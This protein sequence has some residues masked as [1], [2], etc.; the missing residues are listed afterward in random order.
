MKVPNITATAMIPGLIWGCA[1]AGG[2]RHGVY[3]HNIGMPPPRSIRSPDMHS[4]VALMAGFGG[5][6]LLMAFAEIDGVGALRQI[7]NS[8][9]GIR[10]DFLLRTRLL[11]RIRG[12]VYVSGTY[13]RD[14]LLEPEAG[15]AEGHRYSLLETRH[16]M[17]EALAQYRGLLKA[18]ERQPFE[19]LT[20][21]L[22]GYW[23]VLQP[24]FDWTPQQRK[25][26]GFLFLRDEVFRRRMAML[27]IADQI[28]GLNESQLNEGKLRVEQTFSNLR[29]RLTA[30]LGLTFGLGLLLAAA[31]IRRILG[32]EAEEATHFHEIQQLSAGLVEAQEEERRSISRELHDE[33]G[34][35]LTGVLVEMA[36]LSTSIRADDMGAVAAKVD[37]V[38]KLVESSIGV[39]RNMALLLRP[40][41]LDDLGLVPALEWQAREV[42]KRSGVWV[43]VLAE[44]VSEQLPEEHKTCVYRVVQEALHNCVQHAGAS[45][46]TVTV[47]QEPERLLL[48]VQDDGKG[49]DASR[50]KGMGLL[51]IEER[52]SH[53]GG[54]FAV[55][56]QPG[57]G[58]LLQASLPLGDLQ[59]N[60]HEMETR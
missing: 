52:V 42:S 51:G 54:T 3:T 34:Q 32:L 9:D 7:Q 13:V 11:E 16:D 55:E 41:M 58:A 40:A 22:I 1:G 46:V 15:K 23:S 37:E 53:L 33:V 20:A 25:R 60:G 5:L 49:F 59:G 48:A 27:G 4:R 2:S 21:A 8:N 31:S 6:L 44:N 28:R 39:V 24:V 56:S 29:R 12:D 10:E 50:A 47:K 18:P 26:D 35:S 38:K 19:A 17:D 57:S 14:Y 43:K 30:T 45:N 36:N